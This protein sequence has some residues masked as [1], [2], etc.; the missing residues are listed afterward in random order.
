MLTLNLESCLS[1]MCSPP[2][3]TV[4]GWMYIDNLGQMQD[5]RLNPHYARSV[6]KQ[7]PSRRTAAGVSS[8]EDD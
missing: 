4:S 6:L 3:R 5:R 1:S 8:M 2:H 7:W